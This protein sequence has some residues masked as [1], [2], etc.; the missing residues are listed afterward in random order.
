MK[1][2]SFFARVGIFL[3]FITQPAFS[4]RFRQHSFDEHPSYVVIGAFAHHHNAIRFTMQANKM[5]LPAKFEMNPFRKLYY[6]YVLSTEDREQAIEEAKRLRSETKYS[7]TWVYNGSLGEMEVNAQSR[8]IDINPETESKIEHIQSKD[9]D[10]ETLTLSPQLSQGSVDKQDSK[11]DGTQQNDD[12]ATASRLNNSGLSNDIAGKPFFFKLYRA[13]DN[14]TVT[15]E[16]D[17]IDIERTRKM[18]TYQG[19]TIVKVTSPGNKSGEIAFVCEVFGYRKVQKTVNFNAPEAEALSKDESGNFVVPFELTRLQKGD[20]AVMYN[21]YFYKDA[22]VMR[23]ESRYEVESL[24]EMLKENPK[25]KIKIHGHTNGGAHG[26]IISLG[27]QKN[28]FSL[29]NTK[30]GFGSAKKLSEERASVIRDYLASN[31]VDPA[32]MQIKAWGGKRPIHDKHHVRAAE[33]VRVE[34]EILED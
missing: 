8:N 12:N 32:R 29:S 13:T 9:N 22:G 17:V 34:I 18:G 15:G 2:I 4:G 19:N 14:E 25:Y 7:D 28:F 20:I 3:I 21:V 1:N 11:P 33:N 16:V 26:K 23:P 24:L 5:H 6:V 27:D 31:G 30:E 10:P